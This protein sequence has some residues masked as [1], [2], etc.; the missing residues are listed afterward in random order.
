MRQ[1][2]STYLTSDLESI[3]SFRN[4]LFL[5]DFYFQENQ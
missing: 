1:A 2:I 4:D 3:L 5:F